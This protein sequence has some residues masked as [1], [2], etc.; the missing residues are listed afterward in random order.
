LP[1]CKFLQEQWT[2]DWTEEEKH[3]F[4]NVRR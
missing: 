3:I 4:L 2:G 1:E